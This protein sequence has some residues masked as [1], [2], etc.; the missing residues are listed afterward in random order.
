MKT[1][2]RLKSEDTRETAKEPLNGKANSI[3]TQFISKHEIETEPNQV[4]QYTFE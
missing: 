4:N 2:L 3:C 1:Y